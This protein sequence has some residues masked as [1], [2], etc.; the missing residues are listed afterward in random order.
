[1]FIKNSLI[2]LLFVFVSCVCPNYLT[3]QDSLKVSTPNDFV[4]VVPTSKKQPFLNNYF[5]EAYPSPKKAITLAIIPGM[6]QIY[7]K[8]Y[9]KLPLV[10]GALG[11]VIYFIDYNTKNYN[12]LQRSYQS[13][14]DPTLDDDPFPSIPT[15][16]VKS[17][18]DNFDKRR[19]LSWI[20]LIGFYL[21]SAGDAFVDAHLKDFNVDDNISIV[22]SIQTD[23]YQP[24]TIGLSVRVAISK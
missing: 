9:W 17:S 13:K 14:L 5:K 3:G 21:I 7:N 18:R 20:G 4:E 19:Q 16:A 8:R 24:N 22:P 10:Y 2:L 12:L 11:G 15:A 6:G 23:Q 1:M